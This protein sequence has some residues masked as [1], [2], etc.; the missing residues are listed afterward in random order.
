MQ[1]SQCGSTIASDC[2]ESFTKPKSNQALHTTKNLTIR[3]VR[4]VIDY[5]PSVIFTEELTVFFRWR[6]NRSERRR[7]IAI[8]RAVFELEFR[9]SGVFNWSLRTKAND[10]DLLTSG[11][12]QGVATVDGTVCVT[13]NTAAKVKVMWSRDNTAYQKISVLQRN[14]KGLFLTV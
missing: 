12:S 10:L 7:D 3:P 11:R 5:T 14:C 9:G 6:I 2:I 1:V 8:S 4:I 13:N